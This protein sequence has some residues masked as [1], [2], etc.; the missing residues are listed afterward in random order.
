MV[1][2]GKRLSIGIIKL[3]AISYVIAF[4]VSLTGVSSNDWFNFGYIAL[5]TLLGFA[6]SF[7]V[8]HFEIQGGKL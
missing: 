6:L 3:F 4:I 1:Q 7:I 5:I 8:R 2:D